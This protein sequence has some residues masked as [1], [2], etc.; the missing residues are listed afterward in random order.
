[1][2][3]VGGVELDL[4]EKKD[5]NGRTLVHFVHAPK[6]GVFSQPFGSAPIA[7]KDINGRAPLASGPRCTFSQ[8]VS[9]AAS[10]E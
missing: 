4:L 3:E 1:M 8:A 7:R 6:N 2:F 10:K 9:T 5:K